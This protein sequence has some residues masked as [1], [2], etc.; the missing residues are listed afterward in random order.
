MWRLFDHWV[1]SRAAYEQDEW[2][3]DVLVSTGTDCTAIPNV[4]S[5]ECAFGSCNGE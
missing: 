1:R 2:L 4:L 5:V 3:A